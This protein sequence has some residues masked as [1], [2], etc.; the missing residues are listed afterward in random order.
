MLEGYEVIEWLGVS[1]ESRLARAR[2]TSEPG[3]DTC[4]FLKFPDE[5]AAPERRALLE[6]EY[7][8]SLSLAH[9][10]GVLRPI[11]LSLDAPRPVL[12]L[13]GKPGEPL[14]RAMRAPLPTGRALRLALRLVQLV[15]GLHEAGVLHGALRPQSLLVDAADELWFLDLARAGRWDE[16]E[17]GCGGAPLPSDELAYISPEQTGRLN[18]P[19]DF[20]S[21]LYSVGVILYRL[22]GAEL[23]F[24]AGDPLAWVHAHLARTPAP[25]DD[26]ALS[27]IVLRLLSKPPED[28]YQSARGLALDLA[29][30]IEA[31]NQSGRIA[32]FSPGRDDVPARFQAPR[33]LYG[34]EGELETLLGVWERVRG[35]KAELAL[36]AGPSGIGKSSLVQ[37]LRRRIP[38]PAAFFIAGKFDPLRGDIPHSTLSAAFRDLVHEILTGSEEQVAAWRQRLSAALGTNGQL[39]VDVV[40]Q[41]ELVI[42]AQPAVAALPPTEAQNRFHMVFASFVQAIAHDER[43]LVLF[44]D[45]LQWADAA[46]LEVVRALLTSGAARHLLVLGAYR[47]NEIDAAHPL[48]SLCEALA[49]AGAFSCRLSLGPLERASLAAMI[50]GGLPSRSADSEELSEIV[51][52]KTA[53]NPFVAIQL[54]LALCDERVIAFD[55]TLGGF[56]WELDTIR[57]KELADNVVELLI[58]KLRRLPRSTQLVLELLSTLGHRADVELLSVLD[59]SAEAKVNAALQEAAQAGLVVRTDGGCAFVH[60]RVREAAYALIREEDR[61]LAHLRIARR[62]TSSASAAVIEERIFDLAGHWSR[63]AELITEPS[64]RATLVRLNVLFVSASTVIVSFTFSSPCR[65]SSTR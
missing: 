18:R 6:H 1:A 24:R 34:R 60:D 40:P 22:F 64:E 19:V 57:G 14:E 37:A 17:G 65:P 3:V 55:A 13:E 41:L 52:A 56:R 12:V 8:L 29:R 51:H 31:W 20:R 44:L 53:G 45:D 36:I 32:P 42:G 49:R 11:A 33:R 38:A 58:A 61:P 15:A 10:P 28:R 4:V 9:C 26:P 47:D 54:L 7:D 46:S 43:P 50:A 27:A 35:G 21:D 63:G 2:K 30:C 39:V 23:P 25:L 16:H 48:H 5:A 62:W 59:G